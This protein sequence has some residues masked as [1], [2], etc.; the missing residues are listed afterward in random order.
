MRPKQV[1]ARVGD[2]ERQHEQGRDAHRQRQSL[3]R[4]ERPAQARVEQDVSRPQA[5]R[6]RRQRHAA[7]VE[8]VGAAVGESEDPDRGQAGPAEVEQP[9]RAADGHRER[10]DELDRHRDAERDAVN[11]LVQAEV[12]P[13][14]HEPEG[15][16]Q[17]QLPARVSAHARSPYGEQHDRRR[18]QPQERGAS[19]PQAIEQ[20]HRQRRP[21]LDRDDR[22]YDQPAGGRPRERSGTP[23][24]C[25]AAG[26]RAPIVAAPA[27]GSE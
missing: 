2:P 23:H 8:A 6:E 22:A 24:R 20:R 19:G 17:R 14:Q 27:S 11:R 18:Q 10:T 1:G 21:T 15:D 3:A 4:L 9:A 12:H 7:G 5:A 25:F 16:R 26:H 13:S